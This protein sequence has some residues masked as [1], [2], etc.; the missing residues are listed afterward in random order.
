MTT[1][2]E[3]MLALIRGEPMDRV[4]FVQYSGLGGPDEEVWAAFGRDSMGTLRWCG[5]CNTA[6]PNCRTETEE[7][8]LEGAPAWRDTLTTPAGSLT[9][10]R[11]TVPSM[12]VSTRVE[13]YVKTLDDYAILAAYFR[14]VV[15]EPN[16]DGIR[17]A[18]IAAGDDG[19]AHPAVSRTPWQEMWVNWASIEDLS[20][21]LADDPT[22][23]DECLM[24]I[25]DRMME[26][27]EAAC[28]VADEVELPYLVVPDN[29]TAPLIGA[30]RFE[31]YAA[32]Y[33][34]RIADRLAEKGVP[35]ACHMDGDLKA[36]RDGIGNCGLRVIDSFSPT[37]DN[38]TSAAEAAAWWPEMRLLLNFPSSVHLADE[39]TVYDTAM[40]ILE[41]A[42]HTGRL[43]IQVSENPP[44]GAWRRTYGPIIRAISDF[45][46]P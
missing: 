9:Q 41:Q 7:I 15:V 34:R 12:G 16:V 35:L 17:N 19:L 10:V 6:T 44:P 43:Q 5:P 27:A 39:Q 2:R 13:H 22:R 29:I 21:H 23:V 26:G 32:P 31:Q 4:P 36:L 28:T 30:G 20:L 14:D 40:E 1:M 46:R 37:P 38:D 25:G 33:Y 45:G 18:I 11:R 42:G 3:R 24:L 8:V